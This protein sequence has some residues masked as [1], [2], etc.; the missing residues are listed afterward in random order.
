MLSISPHNQLARPWSPEVPMNVTEQMIERLPKPV[1]GSLRRSGVIGTPIPRTVRIRQEGRIRSSAESRWLRFKA[2]QTYEVAVPGFEWIAKLKMGGL[3]TAKARDSLRSG[4]GRMHVKLLGMFDVVD[5]SG[6]EIEQGSL[7]RWLNETMWFP[8]VWTTEL[9]K[10]HDG[11]GDTAFGSVTVGDLT[12]EAEFVFDEGRLV[13]FRADRYRD[14]GDG[15]ELHPWSTPLT[16]HR[17][18]AGIELPVAG[19]AYWHLPG[20]AFDYIQLRLTGIDY[21]I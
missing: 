1:A 7:M 6:P 11:N 14:T 15:Y 13:D 9:I 12:A 21:S 4:V 10:W 20:G 2:Q 5:G 18:M 19:S 16:D 8:A 3:T 17:R